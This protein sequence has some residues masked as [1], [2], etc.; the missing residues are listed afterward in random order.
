MFRSVV[1]QNHNSLIWFVPFQKFNKIVSDCVKIRK[2]EKL[3][4]FSRNVLSIKIIISDLMPDCY[5]VELT[6]F[7][8][9][10]LQQRHISL[11]NS[12]LNL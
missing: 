7:F 9:Y 2:Y 10:L 4:T 6:N 8:L 11:A 5:L 3:G 12:E 1:S